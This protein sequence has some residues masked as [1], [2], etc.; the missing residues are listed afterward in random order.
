MNNLQTSSTIIKVEKLH[1]FI[2]SDLSELCDA[3]E[4]VIGKHL[5]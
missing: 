3:A 5:S 1:S 2:G 4:S